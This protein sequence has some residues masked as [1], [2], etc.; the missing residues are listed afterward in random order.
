MTSI[1][2]TDATGEAGGNDNADARICGG[3]DGSLAPEGAAA[4]SA[5]SAAIL[6]SPV[7]G[8]QAVDASWDEGDASR[9]D[10]RKGPDYLAT[11]TKEVSASAMYRCM[12]VDAVRSEG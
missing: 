5:I 12:S 8:E 9:I 6:G 2:S 10:V 4:A 3:D 1:G 7:A 11:G